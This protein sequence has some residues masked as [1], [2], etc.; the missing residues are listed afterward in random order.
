ME[1][2]KE[3]QKWV[4]V[5]GLLLLA[6]LSFQFLAN[7]SLIDNIN[8]Q[9]VL[10][11]DEKKE[12]VTNLILATS[13]ASLGLDLI[14]GDFGHSISEN[15]AD[16]AMYLSIVLGGIWLQKFLLSMTGIFAFKV[17]IPSSLVLLASNVFLKREEVQKLATKLLLFA[18][19]VFMIIPLSLGVSRRIE[20]QHLHPVTEVIE[21][22]RADLDNLE[23]EKNFFEK[24][25]G[26][27]GD[28]KE[29]VETA[30]GN[31]MEAV[32]VMIVTTCLIPILVFVVFV[33]GI[34]LIFGLNI[35]VNVKNLSPKKMRELQKATFSR[36][37]GDDDNNLL[38]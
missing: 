9:A 13:G 37:K 20:E 33:W 3:H 38:D 24:V 36:V 19:L 35:S 32:V 21:Q 16:L 18:A 25:A 12:T 17:L 15:L 23:E 10:D 30:M 29:K 2:V 8:A 26:L 22:S 1:W 28:A 31:L 34:N 6:I 4:T 27:V 14:P 5:G 7:L 11:L